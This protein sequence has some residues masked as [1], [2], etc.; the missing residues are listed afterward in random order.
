[1]IG[2][3]HQQQQCVFIDTASLETLPDCELASGGVGL[4]RYAA[5]FE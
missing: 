1:M 4:I 5:F 2:A 3:F